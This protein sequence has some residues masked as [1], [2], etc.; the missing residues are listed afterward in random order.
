MKILHYLTILRPVN[1]IMAAGAVWLGAWISSARLTA[2][3]VSILSAAAFLST[4]FGNVIN[5]IIDWKTDQISHADRPIPSG[6]ISVRA[7]VFYSVLLGGYAPLLAFMVAPLYGFATLVPVFTL[8][9]YATF[10]KGTPLVGNLLVALLV[11]YAL[12][13]GSL[14][15]PDFNHLLLPALLAMLLN[16][17]REIIKD[18]QDIAGDTAAGIRTTAALAP[19]TLRT[20][21]FLISIAYL[22]LVFLPFCLGHFGIPYL[23]VVAAGS[24][25]LH[26][27]RLRYM[28]RKRWGDYC[29]KMSLFLKLEMLL[30]LAALG[31]DRLCDIIATTRL[32]VLP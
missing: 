11:A 31:V 32:T 20:I 3:S 1:G 14:E 23:I 9:L 10:L 29:Q 19:A 21:L 12:L 16:L 28:F 4:G 22:L 25:P 30:G 7:A 27:M 24:L 15:A 5:D 17:S 8:I 6:I 26:G 13:F 18:I 2:L